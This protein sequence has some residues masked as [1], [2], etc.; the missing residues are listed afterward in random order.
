MLLYSQVSLADVN[1][2]TN[3]SMVYWFILKAL[4]TCLSTSFQIVDFIFYFV[5]TGNAT[6]SRHLK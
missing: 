3:I 5:K 2:L 1:M 4:S 6:G